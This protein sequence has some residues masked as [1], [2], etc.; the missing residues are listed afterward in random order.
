[1]STMVLPHPKQVRDLLADLLGRDVDI[2]PGE[3]VVPTR[4]VRAAV[5]VYVDGNLSAV[6]AVAADLRLAAHVGAALGLI[7]A[8]TALAAIEEGVLPGNVCE[9]FAEVLNIFSSL[10]NRDDAPHLRLYASYGPDELPPNDIGEMLR[11][12]G[13]RLDLVITVAGYGSGSLSL[14]RRA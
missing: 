6:A 8:N 13:G 5:G 14:V 11:E 1:M 3:P 10:L 4:D 2:A 9:N 7:P 12:F